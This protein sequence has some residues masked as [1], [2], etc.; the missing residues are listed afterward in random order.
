VLV[1]C[2]VCVVYAFRR[3]TTNVVAENVAFVDYDHQE[4]IFETGLFNSLIE[5][6]GGKRL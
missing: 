6:R 4:I 2:F 3:V 5:N 1:K